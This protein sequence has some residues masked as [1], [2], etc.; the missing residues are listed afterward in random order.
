MTSPQPEPEQEPNGELTVILAAVVAALIAGASANSIIGLLSRLAGMSVE[1]LSYLLR[2]DEPLHEIIE[3]PRPDTGAWSE[4]QYQQFNQNIHRRASYLINAGR[5]LTRGL[6]TGQLDGMRTAYEAEQRY[7]QQH[8]RAARNRHE[9]ARLV[10][11]AMERISQ[12]RL[13]WYAVL[14][15]RTSGECRRAHGRNFDPQR[16]PRIGYPGSVHEHCRCR[17]GTPFATRL[18]VEDVLPDAA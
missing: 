6:R 4:P 1:A 2:R 18:R 15:E 7:W 16:I 13:G 3:V 14:D 10:G 17:V 5:R 11:E 8:R 12:V 9:S